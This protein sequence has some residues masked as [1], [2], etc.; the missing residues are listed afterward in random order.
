MSTD[1]RS[2]ISVFVAGVCALIVAVAGRVNAQ[3]FVNISDESGLAAI[4]NA[5]PADWWLSG[6]HFV[7]LDGDGDF[8]F[9]MSSHGSY[10]AL[11]ALNDGTGHFTLAAGSFP[12]T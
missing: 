12:K 11:A 9:F 8:D 1:K 5:Q 3:G 7:D 10:G 2:S 6:L 4:R